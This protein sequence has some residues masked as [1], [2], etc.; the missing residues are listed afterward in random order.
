MLFII[1]KSNIFHYNKR[2]VIE[3][4]LIVMNIFH[5]FSYLYQKKIK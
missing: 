5:F 4:D 3:N 1:K 2:G